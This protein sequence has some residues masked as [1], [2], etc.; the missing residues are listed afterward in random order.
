MEGG[1]E[2]RGKE[3]GDEGRGEW[4]VEMREGVNGGWR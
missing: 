4:R 3:G 1:D 2:G